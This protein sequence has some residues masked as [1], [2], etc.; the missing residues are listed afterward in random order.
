M[1]RLEYLI[2]KLANDT[3]LATLCYLPA[4]AHIPFMTSPSGPILRNPSWVRVLPIWSSGGGRT[5]SCTSASSSGGSL[6]AGLTSEI[7]ADE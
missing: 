5:T 7:R 1:K 6:K 4:Q 3:R 2:S